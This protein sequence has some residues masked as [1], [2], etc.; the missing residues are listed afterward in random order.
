MN[1]L[2]YQATV[3]GIKIIYGPEGFENFIQNGGN[4][5]IMTASFLVHFPSFPPTVSVRREFI[6]L[7]R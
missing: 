7:E 1:G 4:Q 6:S 3:M 5:A 2:E